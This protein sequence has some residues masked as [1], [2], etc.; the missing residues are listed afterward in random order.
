MSAPAKHCPFLNRADSRCSRHFSLD[1]LDSAFEHC[2]GEYKSC[3]VYGEQLAERCERR[4]N[5]SLGR[6]ASDA[7]TPVI[8][9]TF[10][11]C[12]GAASDRRRQYAA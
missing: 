5:A 12:P 11:G 8:Q 9:V 2:F 7:K 3:A 1:R 10:H 4:M 6:D